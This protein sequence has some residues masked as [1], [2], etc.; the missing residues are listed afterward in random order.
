[1]T[2]ALRHNDA[3]KKLLLLAIWKLLWWE[4]FR[5][6]KSTQM[7]AEPSTQAVKRTVSQ[8]AHSPD[9]LYSPT[10]ETALMT[11][12]RKSLAAMASS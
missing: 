11:Q 10:P 7:T 8:V 12:P 4:N 2:P 3:D 9:R 5:S 6:T 1:M